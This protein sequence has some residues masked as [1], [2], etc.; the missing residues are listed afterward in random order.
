M[1]LLPVDFLI[2]KLGIFMFLNLLLIL[3]PVDCLYHVIYDVHSPVTF[4]L[5]SSLVSVVGVVNLYSNSIITPEYLYGTFTI[6]ETQGFGIA[7]MP[8]NSTTSTVAIWYKTTDTKELWVKG[9]SG[10]YY[11]AASNNNGNYYHENSGSPSY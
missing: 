1:K 4:S 6:N 5:K 8:T 2:L 10:S 9:Q 7:T 3:S 11:I